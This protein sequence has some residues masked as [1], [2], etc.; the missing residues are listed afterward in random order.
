MYTLCRNVQIS[1]FTYDGLR[2]NWPYSYGIWV[3]V[4][5]RYTETVLFLFLNVIHVFPPIHILTIYLDI[6]IAYI[7]VLRARHTL[8]Y[9]NLEVKVGETHEGAQD[10][11]SLHPRSLAEMRKQN[12]TLS[13]IP[14]NQHENNPPSRKQEGHYP[15][16]RDWRDLA[17]LIWSLFMILLMFN[18][19]TRHMEGVGNKMTD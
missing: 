1:I 17:E 11:L 4:F 6:L 3:Y 7:D 16:E 8:Q 10:C 18:R 12:N 5:Q 2:Y 15:G 19:K 14:L 9:R 13:L